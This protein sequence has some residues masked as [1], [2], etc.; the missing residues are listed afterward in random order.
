M[1]LVRLAHRWAGGLIGL[2]LFVLGLTGTVLVFK[3]DWLR[4]VVPHAGEA[5]EADPQR[6]GAAL[7]RVFSA[8]DRPRS[9]VLADDWLGVHRLNYEDKTRGAYAAQS[10][11]VVARWDSLWARPELWLFDLHHYLLIGDVGKTIAGIAGLAGLGFVVTGLILW[12]P[13]RR[14]F[15]FA[16]LPRTWKRV[17]IVKHHR[18]MG[19]WAAPALAVV[20][21]TGAVLALPLYDALAMALSPGK[22]LKAVMAAP[23]VQGGALSPDLDWPAVMTAAQ[24]RFPDAK[25]RILSLPTKPGGL[26]SLRLRRAAEWLPN[27]RTQ[28]WFNPADGR[29]VGARDALTLPLGLRVANAQYPI[30]AAKVGGTA[31]RLIVTVAGLALTFLGSLAVVTFWGNPSGSPKRDARR[32]RRR[33]TDD[34]L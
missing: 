1:R 31:Y 16:V 23:K 27:G 28:V 33:G 10:G 14:T 5:R 17:G 30:H 29:I 26:I 2:L 6:I 20:M 4:A 15:V 8:A 3:D 13:T 32:L 22:D 25:P 9:V 18:D 12:W 19:V 11:Q 21:T 7:D 24:H 34:G